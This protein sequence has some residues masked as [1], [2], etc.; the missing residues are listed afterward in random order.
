[1]SEII[2]KTQYSALKV[3]SLTLVI[4]KALKLILNS[5]SLSYI[6][7]LVRNSSYLVHEVVVSPSTRIL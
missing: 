7:A 4:L 2:I 3:T 6:L 1:M 5:L